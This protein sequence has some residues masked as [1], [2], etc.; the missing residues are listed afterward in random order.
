[1]DGQ[2]E[3]LICL[4]ASVFIEYFRKKNKAET[5][6]SKL[7]LKYTGFLVPAVAH[8]EIYNGCTPLQ[9]RF[10]DNLFSD[11]LILP[12]TAEISL[13][14]VKIRIQLKTL[15]TTIEF[16]D[17]SI[18]ASALHHNFSLATINVKHFENIEGL[19]LITPSSF[20]P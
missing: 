13:R 20:E 11:F 19:H 1:M 16:K 17:L 6:F 5:L 8:F 14:A 15:R 7:S 9:I 12:F 3:S 4:D 18:V 2:M 10:W